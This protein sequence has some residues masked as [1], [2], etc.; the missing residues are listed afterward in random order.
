MITSID[1]WSHHINSHNFIDYTFWHICNVTT[2]T[3]DGSAIITKPDGTK[4]VENKD[5]SWHITFPIRPD[6]TVRTYYSDGKTVTKMLPA[7][8]PDVAAGWPNYGQDP[9]SNHQPYW[10]NPN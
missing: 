10:L 6:G 8:G 4:T 5:G 3:P 7:P 9:Y 2:F 1:D